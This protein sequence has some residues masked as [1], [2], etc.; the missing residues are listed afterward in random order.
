MPLRSLAALAL[1][2]TVLAGC[3]FRGAYTAHGVAT[4]GPP[5]VA[6]P[7]LEVGRSWTYRL[8]NGYNS[9][10]VSRFREQV[11]DT[12]QGLEI[13]RTGSEEHV[14][15]RFTPDGK[16]VTKARPGYGALE[17]SPPLEAIPFPLEVG[18]RWRQRTMSHD[19]QSGQSYP[20]L[21]YG[22]VVRWER[23]QTEG[24]AYHAVRIDRHVFI[25]D[26]DFW[27]TDTQ[28][29]ETDWYAPSVGRVVRSENTS[30]YYDLR[31]TSRAGALWVKGNWNVL[32]L[33]S[34]GTASKQGSALP[35]SMLQRATGIHD[36][37]VI[38]FYNAVN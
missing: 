35:P 30:G 32:E 14:T 3:G 33:V 9:E 20:V 38:A 13:A 24:S 34:P 2:S 22:R 29:W 15:E 25:G 21:V 28:V 5:I 23:I 8:V 19:R 36:D 37:G 6:K 10:E 26:G 16:W 17:Y 31:Q 4:S 11:V 7:Q 27:K 12:G 18:K 1:A